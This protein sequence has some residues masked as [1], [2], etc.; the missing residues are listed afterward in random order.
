MWHRGAN[1]KWQEVV[2]VQFGTCSDLGSGSW[3]AV[4]KFRLY[5]HLGASRFLSSSL[6]T[7]MHSSLTNA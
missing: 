3:F 4:H 7:L 5:F 2:M 1:G 6:D